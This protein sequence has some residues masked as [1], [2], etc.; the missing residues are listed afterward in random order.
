MSE[1]LPG[2]LPRLA[3]ASADTEDRRDAFDAAKELRDQIVVEAID[4]GLT[5]R[6]VAKGGNISRALVNKILNQSQV[7]LVTLAD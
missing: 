2:I 7:D 5:Q 3:K 6:D 1:V 4:N